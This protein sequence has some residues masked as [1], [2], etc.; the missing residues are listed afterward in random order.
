MQRGKRK[1]V[2]DEFLA[3]YHAFAN[4]TKRFPSIIRP[5]GIARYDADFV[6]VKVVGK[7]RQH[8]VRHTG[9]EQQHRS[10]TSNTTKTKFHCLNRPRTDDYNFGHLT[11]SV[12]SERIL[13]CPG[14]GVN[15]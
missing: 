12:V 11:V 9:R 2:S 10:T 7:D 6:E 4:A 5:T 1:P 15:N 3:G 13:N 14:S 8:R